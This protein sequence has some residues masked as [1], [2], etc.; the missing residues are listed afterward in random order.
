MGVMWQVREW[1][2]VRDQVAIDLGIMADQLRDGKI[3]TDRAIDELFAFAKV[4]QEVAG[5][6]PE[7]EKY[8]GYTAQPRQLWL[9][10]YQ[11]VI[12]LHA[13]EVYRNALNERL[14]SKSTIWHTIRCSE[15]R[16][17]ERECSEVH[18]LDIEED[19]AKELQGELIDLMQG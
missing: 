14:R 15:C 4:L 19:Y 1:D 12:I 13:L 18:E 7:Q 17:G 9:W 6:L 3:S 10:S 16:K 11:V 8:F 5:I 2:F